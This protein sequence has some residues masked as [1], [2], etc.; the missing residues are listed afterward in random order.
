MKRTL[1]ELADAFFRLG[2]GIHAE[3]REAVDADE[4]FEFVVFGQSSAPAPAPASTV[5][6]VPAAPAAPAAPV[7][8][9]PAALV[10]DTETNGL[11]DPHAVQIAWVVYDA[12]GRELW[13]RV[14]YLALPP[15]KSIDPFAEKVH[16]ISLRTLEAKGKAAQFVLADFYVDLDRVTARGGK[17]VA[18]NAK[19]DARVVTNTATSC[20][21]ARGLDAAECFCTM[22]RS[23]R[24]LNLTNRRGGLKPPKNTELHEAL[25]GPVPAGVQLHDALADVRVTAASYFA[26]KRRE[27]W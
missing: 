24:L 3:P 7:P 16:R 14:E 25:V 20:G 18:H 23:K 26:G 5:P 15:G 4:D 6:T 10:F 27:W 19:F 11:R 13:S 12:D 9:P 21:L 8:P 17:V 1:A 22:E 2:A